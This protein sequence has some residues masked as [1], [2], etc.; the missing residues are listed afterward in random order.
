MPAAA[1][2]AHPDRPKRMITGADDTNVFDRLCA[3]L[4]V[5]CSLHCLQ[6]FWLLSVAPSLAGETAHRIMALC[7]VVPGVPAMVLGWRRHRSG[8]IW[9]WVLPGWSLLLLARFGT[10]PGLGE[11]FET[12]LTAGGCALIWVAHQL[13]RTLAYWHHRS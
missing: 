6:A 3:G 7:V 8:R 4:A 5:G 9:I 1:V 13:N 2:Q 12:F 10:A 11:I